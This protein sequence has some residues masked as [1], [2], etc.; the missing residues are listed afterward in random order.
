[1]ITATQGRA[2]GVPNAVLFR[3]WDLTAPPSIVRGQPGD[4]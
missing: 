1:M 4:K 2:M 3:A